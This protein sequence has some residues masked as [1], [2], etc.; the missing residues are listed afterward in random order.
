[1]I[2][3]YL[4][5]NASKRYPEYKLE[6]VMIPQIP[7]IGNTIAFKSEEDGDYEEWTLIYID[8]YFDNGVFD[9][10]H[11]YLEN[12]DEIFI[13]REKLEKEMATATRQLKKYIY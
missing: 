6:F 2:K 9:S 11:L 10:V 7:N 5:F 12:N 13:E 8:Y 3:A 4:D 1:M